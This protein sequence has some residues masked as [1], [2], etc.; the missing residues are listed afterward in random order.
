MRII[1]VVGGDASCTKVQACAIFVPDAGIISLTNIARPLNHFVK[2]LGLLPILIDDSVAL[3]LSNDVPK[4]SCLSH[5][6]I[7]SNLLRRRGEREGNP[8]LP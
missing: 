3:P 4:N 8:S 2:E 1:A 7:L 6:L 5:V